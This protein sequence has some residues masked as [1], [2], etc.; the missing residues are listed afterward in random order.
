MVNKNV[1]NI[2]LIG[3]PGSGKS[4]VGVILAKKTARA[5]VDTDV[6]I[7]TAQQQTLQ[8]IVDQRGHV[9][10][11]A[12]EEAL[13]LDLDV[14][15]HVIATGGSAVY[16]DAAMAHLRSDGIIVFLDADL[17]T[18]EKRVGDYSGRGIAKRPGQSF[19]GLYAERLGLYQKHADI[20]VACAGM[21][22]EAVC[23]QIAAKL[24]ASSPK[25]KEKNRL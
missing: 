18:L 1:S 22:Q 23:D 17:A 12:I 21:A 8:Q 5:F 7:Q 16:S 4:T 20:T 3:M 9:A 10:L 6:L 15:N 14:K 25:P 2:V 11:R 13:L 19:A 24:T